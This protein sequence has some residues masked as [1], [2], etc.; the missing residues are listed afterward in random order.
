[1]LAVAEDL[2][3]KVG[4]AYLTEGLEINPAQHGNAQTAPEEMVSEYIQIQQT[5]ADLKDTLYRLGK[6][7][8]KKEEWTDGRVVLDALVKIEPTYR[9]AHSL[10]M[11]SY[12]RPAD[13]LFQ[14]GKKDKAK[15]ILKSGLEKYPKDTEMR[16]RYLNS[17]IEEQSLESLRLLQL[18]EPSIGKFPSYNALIAILKAIDNIS[19]QIQDNLY[20]RPSYPIQYSYIDDNEYNR[21]VEEHKE[22]RKERRRE[23]DQLNRSNE[24]YNDQLLSTYEQL[25][26]DVAAHVVSTESV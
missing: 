10:L 23:L 12:L 2:L 3:R 13:A 20:N 25:K 15:G 16:L 14:E 17:L 18:E 6:G 24:T 1:V 26:A 4:L 21:Q 7:R 9:D 22:E 5:Y 8:L 19:S 11:Q